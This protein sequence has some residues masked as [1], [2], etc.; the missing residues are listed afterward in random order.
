MKKLISCTVIALFFATTTTQMGC[1]KSNSPANPITAVPDLANFFMDAATFVLGQASKITINSSSL[2][3]GT[4][5]VNYSLSGAVN[6]VNQT[7]SLIMS[8]GKGIFSTPTISTAGNVNIT[9]NSISNSSGGSATPTSGNTK[10]FTDSTGVVTCKLNGNTYRAV[11]VHTSLAGTLLTVSSTFWDPL[12]TV[13]FHVDYWSHTT[14]STYFNS[15]NLDFNGNN[16]STFNGSAVYNGPTGIYPSANGVITINTI[17]PRLT[18][19]FS[20]KANDS[21]VISVG[22]FDAPA[23]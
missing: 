5:T 1:T 16:N 6:L 23:P 22:T 10:T 11:D 8:G 13:I 18:G 7:A 19:T 21:S 15:N 9:I 12:T 4:F 14:G 20:F 3:D 2:G 17:S